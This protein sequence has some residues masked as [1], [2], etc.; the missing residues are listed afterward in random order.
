MKENILEC[1]FPLEVNVSVKA[2]LV[3]HVPATRHSPEEP[4]HIED[5]ELRIYGVKVPQDLLDAILK[6]DN[7]EIEQ[8]VWDAVKVEEEDMS[9]ARYEDYLE[10][11]EGR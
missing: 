4:A 5:M 1:S 2:W 9:V 3:K 8:Q 11:K 10:S 6:V 7:E